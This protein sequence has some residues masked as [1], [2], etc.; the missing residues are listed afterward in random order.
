MKDNLN[1]NLPE[2]KPA[3][4]VSAVITSYLCDSC[5]EKFTGEKHKIYDENFNEFYGLIECDKCFTSKM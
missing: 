5:G 3:F 1:T 2:E 4:L